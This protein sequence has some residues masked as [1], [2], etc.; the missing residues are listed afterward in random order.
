MLQDNE[1]LIEDAR[2]LFR[3]FAGKEQQ[4]NSEGDRNFSVVFNKDQADKLLAEGWNVKALK[5]RDDEEPDYHMTVKVNYGKGRPPQ[6]IMIT[7]RGRSDL[8][9]DEIEIFD[10]A[11]IKN[12]DLIVRA[13]DWEVNGNKGRKAYLKKIY[14]TI[15]EDDL[16]RKYAGLTPAD[17]ESILDD[18]PEEVTV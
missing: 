17:S 3:N 9:A 12:V 5:A 7:S 1:L 4:Y 14:V 10:W 6:C 13:Y 11:D 8:G 2:L 18:E 15:N 16:D